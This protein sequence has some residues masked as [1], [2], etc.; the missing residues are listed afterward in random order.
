MSTTY[1]AKAGDTFATIARRVY[2]TDTDAD[3]IARANPGAVEPLTEGVEIVI[4]TN[5]GNPTA[6][7][8][9]TS[10]QSPDEVALFIDGKRFRFFEGLSLTRSIDAVDGVSFTAPM[11]PDRQSFRETFKPFSFK[12]VAVTVGGNPFFSGTMIGV[13]PE[14]T[15]ERKAVSIACYSR[16][17]VLM[18]CT[19]PASAFPLEFIGQNLRDITTALI[20]PFGLSMEFVG[21]AGP[22]FDVI[23]CEPDRKIFDFLTDL[24]QQRG[25]VI[26]ST[27]AGALRMWKSVPVGNPIARLIEQQT[28]CVSIT[29]AFQP[30]GFYSHVTGLESESTD[31]GGSQ[32]TVANS[33]LRG[34]VRPYTFRAS[35]TNS[36][37][38]PEAVRAKVGRMFA[39]V[40]SYT[41][42]V[43]TWRNSRGELW[44]PNTTVSLL[45]P[46]AMVYR[47]FRF[48]IR[49]VRFDHSSDRQTAT[50]SLVMPGAFDGTIPDA[51]PWD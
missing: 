27:P 31:G 25:F 12:P 6:R 36:G 14:V 34:V 39:A 46:G 33:R 18:D 3:L 29:P 35:D 10:A 2:G 47:E 51:W 42:D 43:D 49:S 21:N 23:A 24:A 1:N 38:T 4:P 22:V 16:P 28:P 30:Q 7:T 45:A 32:F 8:V 19:P 50:L 44:Q 11:E 9:D 48:L 41:V 26:N 37:N 15:P 17:G 20:R 13:A 5:P 40:A